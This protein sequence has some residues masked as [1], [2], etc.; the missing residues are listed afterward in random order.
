M[1]LLKHII[2]VSL[3]SKEQGFESNEAENGE[4]RENGDFFWHHIVP[5]LEEEG[6]ERGT[7][8]EGDEY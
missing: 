5:E 2:A 6:C 1:D 4:E 7:E 3:L 8:Y